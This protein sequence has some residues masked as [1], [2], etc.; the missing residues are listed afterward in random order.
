M[1]SPITNFPSTS[2]LA[3]SILPPGFSI[4]TSHLATSKTSAKNLYGPEVDDLFGFIDGNITFSTQFAFDFDLSDGVDTGKIDFVAVSVHEI[5]HLLG[6]YSSVDDIDYYM[7]IEESGSLY[8]ST[9]DLYRF[10][11]TIS[12]FNFLNSKRQLHPLVPQ[13]LRDDVTFSQ[14]LSTGYYRGDGNQA[15][16]WKADE[17]TGFNI[18]NNVLIPFFSYMSRYHG[19]D[20]GLWTIFCPYRE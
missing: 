13:T 10:N 2:T 17:I 5:G 20:S 8:M 3:T 16:H 6:F 15:S 4:A 18:G 9:L 7:A 14:Q 1:K 19:S 12:D 11:T